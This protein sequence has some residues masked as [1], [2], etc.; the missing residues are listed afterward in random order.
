ME[1]RSEET[2]HAFAALF[3]VMMLAL[4]PWPS[5]AQDKSEGSPVARL[6]W[7][8]GP[9]VARIGSQAR[10]NLPK[11]YMFANAADTRKFLELTENIPSG[12]ELGLLADEKLTWFVI[13][14]FDDVGYV[15]DD[16]KDSLDADAMLKSIQ[17]GTEQANKERKKR[18]WG[19]MTV[20]GWIQ[21]PH[22]DQDTHNLE[23]SFKG[24]DEKGIQVVNQHTRYLG[25][26]GVT[27]V[28]LVTGT[29]ELGAT[30]P[31]Y[32][33][34]LRGFTYTPDNDYRAF[35]Q[36]DKV[37]EYGLTALVIGG[38]A[39]AAAKTGLLK[40]LWKLLIVGW[41]LVVA[42]IAAIGAF[43][44]RLFSGKKQEPIQPSSAA[45]E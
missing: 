1:A 8:H 4:A 23:W 9:T 14:S 20:V 36:G 31:V 24:E 43:L 13:F 38:A 39:A 26:R 35:V 25:R 3:S 10:L 11:G 21:Q 2:R 27:Q 44:K 34:V 32:R 45:S 7:Q 41:K 37:A 40:G 28:E 15:K 16:E 6:D 33:Q 29:D 22:Y 30:L 5:T 19:T 17:E 42:G 12:K 18:G